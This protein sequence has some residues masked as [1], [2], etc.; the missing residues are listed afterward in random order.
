MIFKAKN[1]HKCLYNTSFY[2]N[3]SGSNEDPKKDKDKKEEE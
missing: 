1:R 2:N 3:N